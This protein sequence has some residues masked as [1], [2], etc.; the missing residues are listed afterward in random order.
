MNHTRLP[1]VLFRQPEQGPGMPFYTAPSQSNML[2][3]Q[4]GS[5]PMPPPISLPG[6]S[7][8]RNSSSSSMKRLSE[9]LQPQQNSPQG[10]PRQIRCASEHARHRHVSLGDSLGQLP[11]PTT[12]EQ[13]AQP[14][15]VPNTVRQERRTPMPRSQTIFW[16]DSKY[17]GSAPGSPEGER[18]RRHS[19][20]RPVLKASHTGGSVAEGSRGRVRLGRQIGGSPRRCKPWSE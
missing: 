18:Q 9:L 8:S 7:H 5:L 13:A 11:R 12:P 10:S 15:S 17:A 19:A 20:V 14:H 3:S 4:Y 1:S 2:F 6:H 16:D